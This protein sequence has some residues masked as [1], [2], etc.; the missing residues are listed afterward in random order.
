VHALSHALVTAS[1]VIVVVRDPQW[2][3]SKPAPNF[4]R[5]FFFR[6]DEPVE[7]TRVCPE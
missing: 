5:R 3:E 1:S 4:H 6:R 2:A 7:E